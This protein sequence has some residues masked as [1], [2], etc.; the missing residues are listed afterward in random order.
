MKREIVFM[1][2]TE[3]STVCRTW[4]FRIT[5]GY[6][7]MAEKMDANHK[8]LVTAIAQ[9]GSAIEKRLDALESTVARLD[10]RTTH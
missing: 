10:E 7:A 3:I 1:T 5:A 6:M 8:E 9:Q 2:K 4:E